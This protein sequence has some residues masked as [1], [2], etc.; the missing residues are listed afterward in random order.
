MVINIKKA[1]GEPAFK[2]NFKNVVLDGKKGTKQLGTKA[3]LSHKK[4]PTTD[5]DMVCVGKKDANDKVFVVY[6][7][8]GP[9]ENEDY[10]T[11]LGGVA[12]AFENTR[13]R[14]SLARPSQRPELAR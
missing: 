9:N 5:S 11:I 7:E 1:S 10:Q 14:S 3:V 8:E 6:Y 2:I 12:K 13:N 4:E